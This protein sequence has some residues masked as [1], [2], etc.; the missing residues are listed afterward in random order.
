MKIRN[1]ILSNK[2]IIRTV[3]NIESK[4]PIKSLD[5]YKGFLGMKVAMKK[6]WIITFVSESNPASQINVIRHEGADVP[7]P[8]I[9]IEVDDVDLMFARAKEQ[10]I[11]IVYP[12]T[13]EPWGVR[14]FFVKDPDGKIINV[15]SHLT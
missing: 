13:D 15:L 12:I 11:E 9:S 2:N 4:T 5:F 6:Q 14:R 7:H 3:P 8:D 1:I 10:K